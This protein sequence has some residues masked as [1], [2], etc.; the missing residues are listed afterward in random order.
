LYINFVKEA[1]RQRV[2]GAEPTE[3]QIEQDMRG[4]LH[5]TKEG[6]IVIENEKP[7]VSA[8]KRL[9]AD[10]THTGHAGIKELVN[11]QAQQ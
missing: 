5:G 3:K 10:D 4:L 2:P 1:V 8:G 9:V 7:A 6:K 11:G